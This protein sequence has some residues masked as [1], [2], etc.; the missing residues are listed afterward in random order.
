MVPLVVKQL[1]QTIFGKADTV[2]LF[3]D[4]AEHLQRTLSHNICSQPQFDSE[5]VW[6]ACNIL[7]KSTTNF[8]RKQLLIY[9]DIDARF[10]TSYAIRN[11][12]ILNL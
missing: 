8:R 11:E 3:R 10:G 2:H 9:G 7:R 4:R 1:Y 6:L 5:F 12:S